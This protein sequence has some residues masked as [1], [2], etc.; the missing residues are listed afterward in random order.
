MM[1]MKALTTFLQC[2][3]SDHPKRGKKER[4]RD[5]SSRLPDGK[6]WSLTHSPPCRNPRKRRDQ[7]LQRHVAEP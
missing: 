3:Y 4:K 7:I 5:P 2:T 6:I 1:R